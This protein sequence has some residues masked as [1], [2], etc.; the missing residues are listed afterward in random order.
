[1]EDFV[2]DVTGPHIYADGL[3][4]AM[5]GGVTMAGKLLVTQLP[6]PE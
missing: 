6:L 1:M 3:A 2:P 5:D 4:L